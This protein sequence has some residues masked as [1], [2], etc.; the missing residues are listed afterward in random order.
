VAQNRPDYWIPALYLRLRGGRIWYDPGFGP[1]EDFEKWQ[2]IVAHVRDGN[3][4]AIAGLGAREAI[5]GDP[6]NL[7][8]ALAKANNFP[9]AAYQQDDLPQVL[10]YLSVTQDSDYALS[11]LLGQIREETLRL[12]A[13]SLPP[14]VAN[15]PLPKILDAL[16]EP[17]GPDQ[18]KNVYQM[19]ADLPGSVYISATADTLMAKALKQ[20]GKKPQLLCVHW[21]RTGD[22]IPVEPAY[23]GTPSPDTPVVYQLLGVFSQADTLV[24]TENDYFDFTIATAGY[25]LLPRVVRSALA[26]SSLLFLGF[27]LTDWSFR[28][29]FRLIQSLEGGSRRARL[30]HVAVQVNPDEYSMA[31]VEKARR[32]LQKYFDREANMGL[33]WGSAEDFLRQLHT[34][35]ASLPQKAAAAAAGDGW[36]V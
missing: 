7:A 14:E 32:Y 36:D 22:T 26:S 2:S 24:L 12:H 33:Y 23:D 25:R 5:T 13:G 11:A 29:L 6:H 4:V 16:M 17:R 9:M 19:L 10:Q 20:A 35:L 28:V 27:H 30:S 34:Q 21:R 18:P 15:A 1:G 31:D 3:F 8:R